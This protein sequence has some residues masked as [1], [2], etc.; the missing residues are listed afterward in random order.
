ML[1]FATIESFER[2]TTVGT[3]ISNWLNIDRKDIPE[4][5]CTRGWEWL[6]KLARD[7]K[8]SVTVV[9]NAI[10]NSINETANFHIVEDRYFW[11]VNSFIY[12]ENKGIKI[13]I[14]WVLSDEVL[15]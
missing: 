14:E 1:D 5:L 7:N 13:P 6:R 10:L 11:Q 12:L 4:I 3:I 2:D 8:T 15:F 9:K